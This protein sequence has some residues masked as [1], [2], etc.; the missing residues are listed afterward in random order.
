MM[1]TWPGLDK[2]LAKPEHGTGMCRLQ[3]ELFRFTM[4]WEPLHS[5][6]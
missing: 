4:R 1:A 2:L 5:L 6:F 3:L